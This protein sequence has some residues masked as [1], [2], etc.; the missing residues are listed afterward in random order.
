MIFN[1]KNHIFIMVLI[2]V[3]VFSVFLGNTNVETFNII[4]GGTIPYGETQNFFLDFL[5]KRKDLNTSP[6]FV[7][8]IKQY[9]NIESITFNLNIKQLKQLQ[10]EYNNINNANLIIQKNE[11]NKI[12]QENNNNENYILEKNISI[13]NIFKLT[14]DT[15]KLNGTKDN[16]DLFLDII[17]RSSSDVTIKIIH[18]SN[19]KFRE[20]NIP[21]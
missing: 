4:D 5:K 19:T 11:L 1:F 7:N 3:L 9:A 10:Q 17:I 13:D 16:Y 8:F 14:T 15:T 21:T 18:Y 12:I 6:R 20:V 2:M